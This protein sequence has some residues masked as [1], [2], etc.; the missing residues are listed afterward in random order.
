MVRSH[1]STGVRTRSA[2]SLSVLLVGIAP[3][4]HMQVQTV[5]EGHARYSNHNGL[6]LHRVM[7]LLVLVLIA[8]H[9]HWQPVEATLGVDI[10]QLYDTYDFSCLV[11]NGYDFAIMRCWDS[12]GSFDGNC[13]GT[14]ADAWAAGMAHVDVYMFPCVGD[15]ATTSVN[16]LY[17]DLTLND[18]TFGTLWLDIEVNPDSACDWS[19]SDFDANC[20]Y[21]ED[22]VSAAQAKGMA[23]GIYSSTYMWQ[24]IFGSA[25]AC[26]TLGSVPLWYADYDGE[27]SFAYY[28]PFG[29]WSTPAMKQW[30]DTG[31][32]CGVTFDE[33]YYPDSTVW[34]NASTPSVHLK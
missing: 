27:P 22:L 17:N 10:S 20:A 1:S 7:C 21:L 15:D 11:N 4:D 3:H 32:I 13:A 24:T 33:N 6:S 9:F 26:D 23:V 19:G 25:A 28:T 12:S 16:D 34:N 29:G 30:D 5:G 31:G 2:H 8:T 14:V 18:V